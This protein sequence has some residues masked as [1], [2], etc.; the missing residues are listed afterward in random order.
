MTAS[1]DRLAAFRDHVVRPKGFRIDTSRGRVVLS[2]AAIL[3]GA[4]MMAPSSW[5]HLLAAVIAG[6]GR[7]WLPV[8]LAAA[9]GMGLAAEATRR[10]RRSVSG[11]A[12]RSPVAERVPLFGHVAVLLLLAA[13]VAVAVGTALWAAFDRP[14]L[15]VSGAAAWSVQDTF[16][17][18]KI[19]LAV[20]AGI[21]GVAGLT[22]AYRKQE[23]SEAAEHRENTKLFND[24]FGRAADQLGSDK[25]AVRLAGVYALAGLADDWAE[26]RQTCIDVLCAYLRLPY[27]PPVADTP[28][29]PLGTAAD[30]DTRQEREVRHTVIRL[31]GDHLQPAGAGGL[32]RWHGHSFN[33]RGATLDGGNLK[34][35]EIRDDTIL[36]FTDATFPT[37]TV[38][39]DRAVFSGGGVFFGRA[40]FSGGTV[41]FSGAA[42]SGTLV[43]FGHANLSGGTVSFG[44]AVFS[45]SP[46]SFSGAVFSGGRADFD[47]AVFS[48]SSADFTDATFSGGTVELGT[49]ADWTTPPT[50]VDGSERGVSWP[51]PGH[52]ATI[53]E[54][55]VQP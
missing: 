25:A 26:R 43:Y 8:L 14:D 4:L 48:G 45:G 42:F 18:M 34:D 30:A 41:D 32:P 24:R 20:V 40:A 1:R 37:G 21:G 23:H 46:M 39:F 35:I 53:I 50:G 29:L 19:V 28:A 22:V 55:Y 2:L 3:L 36:D 10:W 13:V 17:A 44:R 5:W 12:R 33:V 38:G 15:G 16:D 6:L 7:R 52:L 54:R 51:S 47:G 27:T 31:I 49:P 11:A 9:G